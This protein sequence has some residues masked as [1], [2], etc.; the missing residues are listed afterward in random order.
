[1]S[2]EIIIPY[3]LN[4]FTA[5][6]IVREL[7]QLDHSKE[8]FLNFS[9]LNFARPF[10]IL[11]L[12][13]SLNFHFV[14]TNVPVKLTGLKEY[15]SVYQYLAHIGFFKLALFQLG[16]APG[17]ARGSNTYI[18]IEV[19]NKGIFENKIAEHFENTGQNLPIGLFVNN[20]AYKLA[21]LIAGH[22]GAANEIITYCFREIIRN[23]FEHGQT[24]NCMVI[25]QKWSNGIVEISIADNGCG[26]FSTLMSKYNLSTNLQALK[27]AIEP[28]ISSKDTSAPGDDWSNSGFGLFVLSEIGKRLGQFSICSGESLLCYTGLRVSPYD[29]LFKGT[30]VQLRINTNFNNISFGIIDEICKEGFRLAVA[31]SRPIRPSKSSASR[32]NTF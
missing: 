27:L 7:W 5:N 15:S 9:C 2:Q 25:G 10:G 24:D 22:S 17:Q 32:I 31:A 4:E 12:A 14:Y 23:V 13:S 18:P 29:Y 3:E 30:A 21:S 11:I 26:I 28:G 8:I 20:Y 1:M 16:N 6:Q 19:L